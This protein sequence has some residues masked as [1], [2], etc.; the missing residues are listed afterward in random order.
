MGIAKLLPDSTSIG[1]PMVKTTWVVASPARTAM[2]PPAAPGIAR[3]S[4]TAAGAA[5]SVAIGGGLAADIAM[6]G[7]ARLRLSSAAFCWSP[8]RC[9]IGAARSRLAGRDQAGIELRQDPAQDL[10]R[11]LGAIDEIGLIERLAEGHGITRGEGQLDALP[12]LA[13]QVLDHGPALQ[14]AL[15][16]GRIG[17]ERQPIGRLP[18]RRADD[19]ADPDPPPA[20]TA[21]LDGQRAAVAGPVAQ[22][23]G[24]RPP[25]RPRAV[26]G[27]GSRPH[28][29][30][31]G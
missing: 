12:V 25:R 18:E 19:I 16:A 31:P 10:D 20:L 11:H 22:R 27:R 24:A 14:Q 15:L 4:E 5:A 13:A 6:V 30:P 9:F 26:P 23:P 28:P 7:R 1:S 29:R 21:R 17:V 3:S 2:A 8:K